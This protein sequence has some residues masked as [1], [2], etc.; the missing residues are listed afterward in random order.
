M[1]DFRNRWHIL[2]KKAM[3]SR[4]VD[5][6]EALTVLEASDDEI[7]G[8]V[9]AGWEVRRTF[10]GRRVNL[11][12]L[13]N[14]KSGICSE[15]CAFC[16]QSAVSTVPIERYPMRSAEEIV[17][18][19]DEA[20]ALGAAKY[21]IVTSGRSPGFTEMETLILALRKLKQKH[22]RLQLCVSVGIMDESEAR[23]LKEAGADRINHNLETSHNFYQNICTTHSYHDR[24][25]TIQNAKNAGLE[26]CSGGLIGLG[27]SLLD[28]VE[29]A[30]ALRELGAHSIPV[31]FFVPREGMPLAARP[32]LSP[33]ECL[34]TLAMF[35]LVNPLADIRAAGGREVNLGTLQPLALYLA[36]S[37]FTEGY[38][39]TPGQ[40]Y[41]RDLA[42]IRDA[43]FEVGKVEA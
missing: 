20:A 26:I 40:G 9:A 5:R 2:A 10:F 36:T 29:L 15:D 8:I 18:E 28:R 37:I 16:S 42:M 17:K 32:Q 3:S 38:L 13:C 7:L 27:E 12:V 31:N 14:A 41:A 24:V 35:R 39:T 4:G 43:G 23:R 33:T 30:F 6:E 19:G 1:A 25:R 21:C 34:K 22:P 11:H